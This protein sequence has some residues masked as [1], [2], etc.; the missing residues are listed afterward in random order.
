MEIISIHL[1]LLLN[2]NQNVETTINESNFNTSYVVIKLLIVCD[3]S[4]FERI[5][6]HLMLLLNRIL[7]YRLLLKENFNTSYVVIKRTWLNKNVGDG[8]NFNTSYVVIK[9][10]FL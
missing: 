4:N 7:F 3:I 8:H 1:M 5:S 2:D 9:P 10:R 6:I